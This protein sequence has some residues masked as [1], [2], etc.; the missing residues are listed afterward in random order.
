MI[1]HVMPEIDRSR[2][3]IR[4]RRATVLFSGGLDST[5]ALWWALNH[6][7]DVDTLTIDYGQQHTGELRAAREIVRRSHTTGQVVTVRF[8]ASRRPQA[9]LFLRGHTALLVG[10]AAPGI[11]PSG[12]DIVLGTLRTD[13]F[14]DAQAEYA[15]ALS[16]GFSGPEDTDSV[17]IVQPLHA[18]TGKSAAAAVGFALGAPWHLSWSCRT[19]GARRPCGTCAP[20]Q[21]RHSVV[22]DVADMRGQPPSWIEAWQAR[23]GSPEHPTF[24]TAT[25]ETRQLAR[26]FVAAGGLHDGMPGWRYIAPDGTERIT[27]FIRPT[28]Q[29]RLRFGVRRPGRHVRATGLMPSTQTP[30]ELVICEDGAVAS[31][32]ELPAASALERAVV[33]AIAH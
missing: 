14:H 25:K 15:A 4:S 29:L 28:R 13:P 24:D 18:V 31:S 2:V 32:P 3:S 22:A 8:P 17:A 5:V 21:S 30:W 19:A 1:D 27:P 10:L 26:D 23:L 7:R 20:C 12:A 11:G 6:Y 16:A 33:Q 9:G